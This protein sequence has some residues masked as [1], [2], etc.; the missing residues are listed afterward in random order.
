M[1]V[2][3]CVKEQFVKVFAAKPNFVEARVFS[4]TNRNVL[5][6]FLRKVNQI[7]EELKWS[8]GPILIKTCES[9]FC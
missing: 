2:D 1:R 3:K 6:L 5:M 4:E 9:G 8:D 7:S